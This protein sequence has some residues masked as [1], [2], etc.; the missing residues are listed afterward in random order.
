MFNIQK[1]IPV[2]TLH[3]NVLYGLCTCTTL[4]ERFCIPEMENVYCAVRTESL[5]K[6]EKFRL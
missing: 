1:L 3:L 6:R 2:F 5:H 4:R